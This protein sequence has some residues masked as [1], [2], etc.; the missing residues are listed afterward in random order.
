MILCNTSGVPVSGIGDALMRVA[1]GKELFPA[2]QWTLCSWDAETVRDACGTY[3]SQEE[4]EEIT[5]F[6]DDQ[7][8]K[9]CDGEQ[10]YSLSMT[11]CDK[12]IIQHPYSVTDVELILRNG[13]ASA[14]HQ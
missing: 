4:G 1:G 7:G 10:T 11:G 3:R 8:V 14:M 9:V 2:P 6:A 12:A 13:T 5:L